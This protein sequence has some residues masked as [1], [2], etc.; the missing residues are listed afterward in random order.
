MQPQQ[1]LRSSRRQTGII[2]MAD[3]V[4]QRVLHD[5]QIRHLYSRIQCPLIVDTGG[6]EAGNRV[7]LFFAG[8]DP[9]SLLVLY[10]QE[11]SARFPLKPG[12]H[13][14]LWG[15]RQNY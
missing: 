3:D 11:C 12:F 8:N 6:V 9:L 7:N 10:D 2:G 13:G 15:S 1:L 4:D 14:S 5:A